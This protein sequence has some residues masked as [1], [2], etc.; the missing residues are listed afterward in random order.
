MLSRF[1]AMKAMQ[2]NLS[3]DDEKSQLSKSAGLPNSLATFLQPRRP[4]YHHFNCS[5]A[6]GRFS[7]Q[8]DDDEES[9]LI[10]SVEGQLLHAPPSDD[11]IS[12]ASEASAGASLLVP[13]AIINIQHFDEQQCICK[14]ITLTTSS[15][16]EILF[17]GLAYA[18]FDPKVQERN[19][20]NR[21]IDRF[22]AFYGVEPTTISPIF[23]DLKIEYPDTCF[24]DALMTFNWLNLY[25]TYPVL[26]G[27]WKRCEEYIGSKVWDYVAKISE[28]T[29]RRIIFKLKEWKRLGRTV[30][31]TT[32]KVFEMRQDPSNKWFDYKHH[33]CGVKY[34]TCLAIDEPQV[35]WIDGPEVPSMHDIT[36]FRG[37][38]VDQD[39]EDWNQDALYFQIDE[40]ERFVGD[41]GY[42]GEPSKVVVTKDEHSSEF[43]HFLA[44]AKNRHETFHWRLKSWNILG[45]CFRHGVSTEDRMR[46][47]KIVVNAIAGI[48]QYDYEYGHPP[49]TVR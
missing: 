2:S 46:R 49:F 31:C 26:S 33:S 11:A 40:D 44:R 39:K 13:P 16:S 7:F 32:F 25:D 48:V 18:G 1:L 47:H 5:G 35:C 30:D 37:G 22:Q 9:Q 24:K 28:V 12:I 43:K 15:A 3:D 21:N 14:Q 4:Q 42:N 6:Q 38:E 29:K 45:N 27:R 36:K 23:E 17:A 41:S 10:L 34:E 19:N 20:L 8:S